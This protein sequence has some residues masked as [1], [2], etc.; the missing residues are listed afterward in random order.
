MGSALSGAGDVSLNR[1]EE[2]G[3]CEG[4]SSL[5]AH[6]GNKDTNI[7]IFSFSIFYYYSNVRGSVALCFI[8]KIISRIKLNRGLREPGDREVCSNKELLMWR[9][10]GA[11]E[12]S[13]QLYL[14]LELL[15]RCRLL[16]KQY[17]KYELQRLVSLLVG[18]GAEAGAGATARGSAG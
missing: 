17:L 13:C 5:L 3:F 8:F 1:H 14:P 12:K 6:T 11:E 16:K 9:E 18:R 4:K 10:T 7:F 2:Q 15:P